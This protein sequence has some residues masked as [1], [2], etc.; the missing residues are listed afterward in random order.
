MK[1]AVLSAV[2]GPAGRCAAPDNGAGDL[3]LALRAARH[4]DA[5]HAVPYHFVPDAAELNELGERDLPCS[6]ARDH[7]GA[8]SCAA[9][10]PRSCATGAQR[11]VLTALRRP[12]WHDRSPC[13][14][15]CPAATACL[16][17]RDRGLKGRSPHRRASSV[18]NTATGA[19]RDLRHP[20]SEK[21]CASP[22]LR[23]PAARGLRLASAATARRREWAEGA[24]RSPT[25]HAALHGAPLRPGPDA[26]AEVALPT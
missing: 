20:R 16:R 1:T 18:I 15:A 17:P 9:A 13:T 14:T 3:L 23:A 5:V 10:P 22:T 24:D 8:L 7:A 19:R 6:R 4:R 25:R 11:A 26:D 12:A 2:L 21:P